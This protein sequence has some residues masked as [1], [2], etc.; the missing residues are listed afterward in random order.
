MARTEPARRRAGWGS[1]DAILPLSIF[2]Q[3][4]E[5]RAPRPVARWERGFAL[6]GI[7]VQWRAHLWRDADLPR[8]P[9]AEAAV[10][11][12]DRPGHSWVIVLIDLTTGEVCLPLTPEQVEGWPGA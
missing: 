9:H 6:R 7:P 4:W 8:V 2:R 1:D 11:D 10:A 5:D 3:E 12:P